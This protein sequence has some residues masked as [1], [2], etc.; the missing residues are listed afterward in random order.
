MN[1]CTHCGKELPAEANFCPACGTQI[2]GQGKTQVLRHPFFLGFLVV[3]LV[4][5]YFLQTS[6]GGNPPTKEAPKLGQGEHISA[7]GERGQLNVSPSVLQM[8]KFAEENPEDKEAWAGYVEVLSQYVRQQGTKTSPALVL[9]LVD[10]LGKL[11][12]LDPE[13]EKLLLQ[14]ADISFEQKAFDKAKALYEEYLSK[15]PKDSSVQTRLASA[16]AFLGDIPG[17]RKILEEVIAREP[18]NFQAQAYLAISYA[19]AG[20]MKKAEELGTKALPFAPSEEAKKR[21][22]NFLDSLK[23]EGGKDS[24]EQVQASSSQAE[25]LVEHIRRN[26]IAGPKLQAFAE[27]DGILFLAFQDFPMAAMP[28][29]ARAKFFSG[30]DEKAKILGKLPFSSIVFVEHNTGEELYTHT[31]P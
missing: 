21:F 11:R 28:E 3:L 23:E 5:A 18:K 17:S 14:L 31:L 12:T 15:H 26:P 8:R 1:Y 6:L 25:A 13:N 19:Q 2:S 22:K 20:D 16:M 9:E 10:A 24:A 27:K 4:L 30:I 29:V 7:Q